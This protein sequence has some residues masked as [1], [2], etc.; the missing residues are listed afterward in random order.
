M[1]GHNQPPGTVSLRRF[2]PRHQRRYPPQRGLLLG[3]LTQPPLIGWITAH[4]PVGGMAR[5]GAVI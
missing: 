5:T 2:T 1:D 4:P 3:Q